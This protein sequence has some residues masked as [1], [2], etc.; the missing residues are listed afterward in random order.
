MVVEPKPSTTSNAPS[1]N[2]SESADFN[3]PRFILVGIFVTQSRGCGPC[4]LPPPFQSGERRLATR[5]RPV[6]FCFR[7]SCRFGDVAASL[8][9]HSSPAL[10]GQV[11]V[12]GIIDQRFVEFDA[13]D[14]VTKFNSPTFRYSGF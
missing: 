11:I 2:R 8:G 3:A 9:T 12:D 1:R 10:I 7:A 13:E 14:V 6:P 4:T 5:A